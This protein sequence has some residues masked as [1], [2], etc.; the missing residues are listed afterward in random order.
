MADEDIGKTLGRYVAQGSIASLMIRRL[1]VWGG[2][3]VNMTA[4]GNGS[5]AQVEALMLWVF[6]DV[7]APKMASPVYNESVLAWEQAALAVAAEANTNPQI[8]LAVSFKVD[9]SIQAEIEKAVDRDMPPV[10]AS[11]AVMFMLLMMCLVWMDKPRWILATCSTA[12]LG[13]SVVAQLGFY[14]WCV[15]TVGFI[16]FGGVALITMLT[17][18]TGFIHRVILTKEV[19]AVAHLEPE[20]A[21]EALAASFFTPVFLL[22]FTGVVVFSWCAA[23]STTPAITAY[24]A[25]AAAG[26]GFD[27]LGLVFVCSLA[28]S[29]KLHSEHKGGEK[30]ALLPS[31]KAKASAHTM[32][33]SSSAPGKLFPSMGGGGGD[34]GGGGTEAEAEAASS[35]KGSTKDDVVGVKVEVGGISRGGGAVQSYGKYPYIVCTT[36][37]ISICIGCIAAGSS[38]FADG[39]VSQVPTTGLVPKS[40][41]VYEWGEASQRARSSSVLHLFILHL[42]P[43][44]FRRRFLRA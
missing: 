20:A 6:V 11:I 21:V 39:W 37:A 1:D 28:T 4:A 30:A 31:A 26:V 3:T 15:Y 24:A 13:F 14:G 27:A 18:L 9:S 41:Y 19:Q 17:M 22:S 16:K 29:Y 25:T 7:A 43:F 2:I 5:V 23:A 35:S 33:R 42:S 38:L 10:Y 32:T 44:A 12:I 36:I 8:P 34:S 40:S